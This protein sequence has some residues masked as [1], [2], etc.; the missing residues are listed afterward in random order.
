[1]DVVYLVREG[2][3]NEEL[4][5]SLR[6][7]ANVPHRRVWIV[8]HRPAWVRDVEHIPSP[9]RLG[10]W[11]N[12]PRDLALA[13]R[14][15]DLSERFA[16]WNDD[17]FALVPMADI[18][19]AHRGP[20]AASDAF[21]S[22]P[23]EIGKRQTAALLRAWGIAAPLCYELHTPLVMPKA[24]AADAIE[25]ALAERSMTALAYRSV[26]GNVAGLGGELAP[27]VKIANHRTSIPGD[28]RWVSTTDGSFAGGR[29]GREIRARFPDPSPY[30]ATP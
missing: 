9:N 28:A 15:P 19:P 14:H 25:R 27:D 30:E 29:V 22:S 26:V 4:R 5:H 12:L 18:P 2:V 16:Y 3:G 20:L 8:G 23:Y 21:T 24:V 10:K 1:M 7:L 11:A 17:M 13:A 6:S